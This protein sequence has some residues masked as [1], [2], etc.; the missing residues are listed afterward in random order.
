MEG[1]MIPPY[2]K[3]GKLARDRSRAVCPLQKSRPHYLRIARPLERQKIAQIEG[4]ETFDP[5]FA[6]GEEV[7]VVVDRT[8]ANT[9][10]FG[11]VEGGEKIVRVEGDTAEFG[12]DLAQQLGGIGGRDAESQASAREGA[13][14]FRE[15]VIKDGMASGKQHLAAGLVIRI[16]GAEG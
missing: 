1:V 5:G 13:K 14:G 12:R 3:E 11:F 4:E 9:A 8:A 6:G 16:P 10:S 7:E 2:L 15:R